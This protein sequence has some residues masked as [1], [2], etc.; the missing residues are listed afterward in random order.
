MKKI[1]V[2]GGNRL[3]GSI[4]LQGAKNSVLPIMAATLLIRGRSVI[5]N[6]PRLS[7]LDV[8]I[9]ILECLGCKCEREADTVT[10]DAG[11]VCC[12][13]IPDEL[14]REMRSSVMF[15]GAILARCKTAVITAP[16]GCELGPRP[17]DIHL[18][19]LSQ[20]GCG[21]EEKNGYIICSS[22]DKEKNSNIHLSFP[23]VG[24]TENVILASVLRRGKTVISGV[25]KEPEIVDLAAFLSSAGA[26]ISGAGTD[27]I[28]IVGVKELRETEHSVIPDRIVAA[29]YISAAA[30]TGSDIT[31][32]KTEPEHLTAILQVFGEMGISF[33]ISG[34]SIT[35]LSPKRLRAIP[36]TKTLVYPGFPTDAGPL[37]LAA[38][39]KAEGSSVLVETIFE[40]R[41]RYVEELSR[42]SADIRVQN[43]VA[44][45][46][47]VERL[48]GAKV[49]CTDLRGGAALTVA[50]LASE[51]ITEIDKIFHIERGYESITE[52]LRAL[53]AKIKRT[54]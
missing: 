50:A 25:A 47:G 3:S 21:I 9:K 15:L 20:L 39:T 31:L 46:N 42:M 10:V 27:R 53:G 18:K 12:D 4:N 33:D 40:N 49:S 6:C 13:R 19:A 22:R 37:L 23:S 29:T 54:E 51:G 30:I 17:I 44:V 7:D 32:K 34:D 36:M 28:E 8:A 43:K 11:N 45:I 52:D 48:C 24:A 16:G 38:L 5:H 41:F 2:E 26:R 1:I 35:V 14:M